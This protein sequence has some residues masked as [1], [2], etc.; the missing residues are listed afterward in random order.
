MFR[1]SRLLD[2][3]T[4]NTA[5][6]VIFSHQLAARPSSDLAIQITLHLQPERLAEAW[7]ASC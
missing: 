1:S 3:E 5:A 2:V 7:P 4:C 6:G